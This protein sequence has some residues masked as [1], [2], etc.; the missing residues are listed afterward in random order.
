M[1][2]SRLHDNCLPP[3]PP[4]FRTKSRFR[5]FG[6]FDDTSPSNFRLTTVSPA[7]PQK[8]R[9]TGQYCRKNRAERKPFYLGGCPSLHQVCVA[10][11]LAVLPWLLECAALWAVDGIIRTPHDLLHDLLVWRKSRPPRGK[12]TKAEAGKCESMMMRRTLVNQTALEL[13]GLA[14][15]G[16][17][18]RPTQQKRENKG[19]R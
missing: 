14:S 4:W 17:R 2:A 5:H 15:D 16:Q 10:E 18:V 6:R 7:L 1:N 12:R 3:Y 19:Q 8:A 13:Q 9:N 11:T